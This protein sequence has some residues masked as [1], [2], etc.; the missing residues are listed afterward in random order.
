MTGIIDHLKMFAKLPFS[1]RR[2][3]NHRLTVS[4][5][6]EFVREQMNRREENFLC[7][8]E[9]GIFGYRHS[10]YLPLLKSAGC[11]FGDLRN[12]VRVR[13]LESTLSSLCEAGVYITFEEFKGRKPIIRGGQTI[14]VKPSDFDNP[15]LSAD[16]TATTGGSSGAAVN[17][18]LNLEYAAARA[19]H[20]LI[21]DMAHGI[22]QVPTV[23]WDA[24]LPNTSFRNTLQ[25]ISFGQP[26]LH[27]FTPARARDLR[28]WFKYVIPSYYVLF[29]MNA[30]GAHTPLPRVI[31]L[32]EALAVAR[33]LK[34]ILKKIPRCYLFTTVSR[35]LRVALAAQQ[36]GIDLTGATFGGNA[37]PSTR[38]K[39]QP[40]ID[41]GI[42]YLPF[43]GMVETDYAAAGCARP[44]D[45]SD[46]HLF[47]DAFAIFTHPIQVAG[48]DGLVPAVNLTTLFPTASK[49][50][51]NVQTDDFAV[52]EERRCGCE[53][54]SY[55][56]TTHLREIY[57]YSKLV[58]EGVTL[59][60]NELQSV[61]ESELPA[62]FGGS[63][64]DYQFLEQ[65]DETGLTRLYL[66]VSPR[67]QIADERQVVQTVLN[68]LQKLSPMADVA[69]TAW[70]QA[71][72][73][74]IK[75][76]DP[77]LTS[78]GKFLALSVQRRNRNP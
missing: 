6:Q 34:E 68:A 73:I 40:I 32:D 43:Y 59:I 25:M 46:V 15:T 35:A 64:L 18:N 56:Y 14:Q 10:P 71:R 47:K 45:F 42:K 19:P 61:L 36:A 51:V 8:V 1:L 23:R 75:R 53:L 67:V 65:E 11:E 4:E 30:L 9:R 27:W 24:M 57:S 76:I 52:V 33:A 26:V 16:L 31:Q 70:R 29:W 3:L 69:G 13:G 48:F 20:L 2:F 72:T 54:E 37:E 21:T 66:V 7:L 78:R 41:A 60:G 63:P 44:I 17:V 74:Q 62:R 39:V 5:A 49:V 50:M 55:G 77:V 38:A 28:H 22:L 58:G 12:M